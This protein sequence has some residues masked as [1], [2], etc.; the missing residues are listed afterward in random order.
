MEIDE[1]TPPNKRPFI[2]SVRKILLQYII[3]ITAAAVLIYVLV[4]PIIISALFPEY[5]TLRKYA[6][7]QVCVDEKVQKQTGFFLPR[8]CDSFNGSPSINCVYTNPSYRAPSSASEDQRILCPTLTPS[9][10]NGTPNY[11]LP[12]FKVAENAYILI[13]SLA[14]TLLLALI[15]VTLR[16][17]ISRRRG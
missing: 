2:K 5:S 3:P 8:S 16:I 13:S 12:Q 4:A 6:D 7:V 17:L 10:L 14:I 15:Y 1:Q 9:I 11:P